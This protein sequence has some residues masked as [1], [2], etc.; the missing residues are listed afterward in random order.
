MIG[1]DCAHHY[2]SGCGMHHGMG[3]ADNCKVALD[4]AL[5]YFECQD[6]PVLLNELKRVARGMTTVPGYGSPVSQLMGLGL[7]NFDRKITNVGRA[8]LA[9]C[10][11]ANVRLHVKRLREIADDEPL[12]FEAFNRLKDAAALLL[13][14]ERESEESYE[15]GK[16]EGYSQAVADIDRLTGGDGE[17]RC[18]I[19]IVHEGHCP[20]PPS[21]IARIVERFNERPWVCENHPDKPSGIVDPNGCQC[22][23]AAMPPSQ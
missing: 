14:L 11:D 19:G 10:G 21:M 20:D 16:E 23:G 13:A 15:V 8:V 22:G 1:N 7:V 9:E 4:E 5:R 18:I 2:C 6:G 17:Y 12:P 3:H